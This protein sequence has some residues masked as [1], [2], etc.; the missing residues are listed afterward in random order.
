MDRPKKA[1]L[2]DIAKAL[3]V[4][5]AS[6][7]RALHD[8]D[9]VGLELRE[10]VK[11]LAEKWNYRPNPFAQS[12]RKGSPKIIGVVVPSMSSHFHSS[13]I[14]G[15]EDEARKSGYSVICANSHENRY[16]EIT[17]ID[18]L[19]GMHVDGIIICLSQ[20]TKEY[21]KFEELA[22]SNM[23]TVLYARTCLNDRLSSVISDDIIASKQATLHLIQ[24]GCCRI[25]FI[26]GP[27]HLDMVKRRKHGFIEALHEAKLRVNPKFFKCAMLTREIAYIST[28]QLIEQM[29]VDAI[30]AINYDCVYGAIDAIREKGLSIPED[31]ALIGFVDTPDVRYLTPPI[32]SI[33]DKSFYMGQRLCQ[34]LLRHIGGDKKI[35]HEVL[36]MQINIR[37]SSMRL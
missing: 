33:A 14:A 3:G 20:E 10:K 36:P 30:M 32:S 13:V 12:L 22:D 7:S 9:E 25:G 29:Q 2:K 23:P 34:I 16:D 31:I 8:S 17:C 35:L 4:S 27:N 11:C 6:V 18:N 1:S 19:L 37:K 28:K 24:Q 5:V 21:G 26:G 15:L